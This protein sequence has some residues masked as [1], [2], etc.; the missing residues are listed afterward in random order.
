MS[1]AGDARPNQDQETYWQ[2]DAG[3]K[4]AEHADQMDRRIGHLGDAAMDRLELAPGHSVLDVGCGCG[5]T[6]L[7]MAQRVGSSGSATGVDL[8][9]VMLNVARTRARQLGLKNVSFQRADVQTHAFSEKFDAIYSRFGVMFFDNPETA[10]QNLAES[11]KPGGRLAF[12]CWCSP[13]INPWLAVPRAAIE[14]L[15]EMPPPPDPGAPGPF[16]FADP[17]RVLGL[18]EQAGLEGG[19][20]DRQEAVLKLGPDVDSA[21]QFYFELGPF[22]DLLS[23]STP[24]VRERCMDALRRALEPFQSD[25]GVAM[26]TSTWLVSAAR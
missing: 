13:K 21:I 15:V 24:T 25:D 3:P 11:L 22:S 7:Q 12:V 8:S 16:A 5:A 17:Q 4:W 19:T 10:F 18:L 14:D 20:Y 6:A 2:E 9:E 1:D 23:E 26:P